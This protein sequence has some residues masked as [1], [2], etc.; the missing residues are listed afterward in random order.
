[1]SVRDRN[2][3]PAGQDPKTPDQAAL[4]TIRTEE[5]AKIQKHIAGL[6]LPAK[7]VADPNELVTITPFQDIKPGAIPL[8]GIGEKTLVWLSHYWSTLGMIGL[9]LVSLLVLRSMVRAV[10]STAEPAT[11]QM[12]VAAEPDA[13][14]AESPESVAARRLRRL[15]T[16]G[17][18]L[19]DELSDLVKEDPDAAANILRSWIGQ[20]T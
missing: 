3:V 15:T 7:G 6:G 8:P 18:S 9:G 20:A 11:V 5:S 2:P 17:P 12:R 14:T 10:P 19:R 16:G 4:E 13:H 1:M